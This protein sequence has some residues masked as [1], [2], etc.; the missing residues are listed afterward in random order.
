MKIEKNVLPEVNFYSTSFE[1]S[2]PFKIMPTEET[3]ETTLPEEPTAHA[4]KVQVETQTA[5]SAENESAAPT[6]AEIVQQENKPT[7]EITQEIDKNTEKPTIMEKEIET[8]KRSLEDVDKNADPLA[9]KA[10][11]EGVTDTEEEVNV[12]A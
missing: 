10:K 6:A 8:K 2:L 9:K 4:E 11:T 12:K 7:G 3:I 1:I 5:I